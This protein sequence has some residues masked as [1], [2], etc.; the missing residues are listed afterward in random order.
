MR[1]RHLSNYLAERLQ[2]VRA[3]R[4]RWI[5]AGTAAFAL[6][7]AFLI[8]QGICFSE[9]RYHSLWVIC[10][11][12]SLGC[13][14]AT[15]PLLT[16]L[17]KLKTGIMGEIRLQAH[18]R[19]FLPGDDYTCYFNVPSNRGDIDC[20]VVGPTGVYAIEAKNQHGVITYTDGR[21]QN[22]KISGRGNPYL[23][24]G[25]NPSR[26][27]MAGVMALK[28]YLASCDIDVWVRAAVVFT[29]STVRI[30]HGE[31]RGVNIL[32][33]NELDNLFASGR[34]V[35]PAIIGRVTEAMDRLAA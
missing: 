30:Y 4:K 16:E 35:D 21:W 9:I 6:G 34:K 14:L 25:F 31:T 23:G 11:A 27:I 2:T 32:H 19:R 13:G 24:H 10:F 18:L 3:K 12:C 1:T 28:N 5:I 17:A 26:Q 20:V 7:L 29:H 33:V 8:G 15:S 22:I